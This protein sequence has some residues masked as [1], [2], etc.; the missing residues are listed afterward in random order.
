MRSLGV[1]FQPFDTSSLPSSLPH[2]PPRSVS[3]D[4]SQSEEVESGG[5]TE[6][7][8]R[9]RGHSEQGLPTALRAEVSHRLVLYSALSA[10]LLQL[11]ADGHLHIPTKRE[12][13]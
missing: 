8:G 6:E 1:P 13:V 10:L 3:G 9:A 7:I 5:E 12:S 11:P 4:I 2:H